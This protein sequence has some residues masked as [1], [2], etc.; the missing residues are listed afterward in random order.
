M[1]E[2]ADEVGDEGGGRGVVELARRP[3]LGDDGAVHHDDP[4]GDRQ[5]LGLVVGDVDDGEAEGLLQLADLVADPAAQL[6][7]EVRERLVEEQHLRLE[8]QRPG[9]GDALLLAAGELGGEARLEAGEPDEREAVGGAAGGLALVV[10]RE[11]QAVGD[12]LHHRHVREERVGLEHHR[13]VAV[14]RRQPGDVRPADQ[15]APRRRHL[16]PGDHPE[17]RRL[18]AA[19]GAEQR[20][21]RPGGDLEGDV[22]DG[23]RGA[24]GIDLGHPLEGDGGGLARDPDHQPAP[25]SA[26]P[27]GGMLVRIPARP[28]PPVPRRPIVRRPTASCIRPMT[29]SMTR[30]STVA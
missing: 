12:V 29:A 20:D 24:A 16:E 8:H 13:H 22:V 10:A 5:R 18:A 6:G 7:V 4:V 25:A 27:C 19:R 11:A 15:D 1:F 23:R 2:L 17:R 14:G 9:D 3:L 30:I 28:G 21:Q 26:A